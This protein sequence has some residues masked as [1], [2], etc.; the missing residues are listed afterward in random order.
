MQIVT[1]KHC[2]DIAPLSDKHFTLNVNESVEGKASSEFDS[3]LFHPQ[4]GRHNLILEI[5]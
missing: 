5:L 3:Y 1:L 2:H 4:I